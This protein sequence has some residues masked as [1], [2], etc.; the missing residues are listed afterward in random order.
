MQYL[1]TVVAFSIGKPFRKPMG[2]NIAFVINV[3]IVAL[4]GMYIILV[5][6]EGNMVIFGVTLF[7][8]RSW[9]TTGTTRWRRRGS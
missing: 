8:R 4:Y 5:P 9:H 3:G 1:S 2:S 6:D 7:E